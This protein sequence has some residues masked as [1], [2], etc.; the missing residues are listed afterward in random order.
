MLR[1]RC[2]GLYKDPGTE[3]TPRRSRGPVRWDVLRLQ[4]ISAIIGLAALP[5]AAPEQTRAM[6]VWGRPAPAA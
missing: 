3:K 4:V 2:L 5:M 6:W 1:E